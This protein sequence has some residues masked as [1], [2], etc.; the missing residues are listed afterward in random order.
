MSTAINAARSLK[1]NAETIANGEIA[2]K[3][4]E[5]AT[6]VANKKN[7]KEA[8]LKAAAMPAAAA[9]DF[10]GALFRT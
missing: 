9:K 1:T 8:E 3:N 4:M 7:S 10:A 2:E 6:E 5:V